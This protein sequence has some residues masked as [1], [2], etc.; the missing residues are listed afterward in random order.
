MPHFQLIINWVVYLLITLFRPLFAPKRRGDKWQ[1]EEIIKIIGR[2]SSDEWPQE[3]AIVLDQFKSYTVYPLSR[4][5]P[6]MDTK[7][8][9]MIT[10][11]SGCG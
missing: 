8:E 10:V 11:R 6:D 5:I 2:P 7:T 4:Y 9:E 1:L 3:T